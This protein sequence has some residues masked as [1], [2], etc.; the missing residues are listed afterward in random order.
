MPSNDVPN[1]LEVALAM[2]RYIQSIDE[3]IVTED[4]LNDQDI[5]VIVRS[6][7]ARDTEQESD[8]DEAPLVRVKE[9]YNAMQM[10]LRYKEQA[11]SESNLKP[12]ELHF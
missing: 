12:E 7:A 9:V 2:E 3:P 11:S 4:I 8:E 10:V 1:A 5:I 6:K